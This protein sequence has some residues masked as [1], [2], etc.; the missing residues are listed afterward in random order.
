LKFYFRNIGFFFIGLSLILYLFDL[1][2]E[3]KHL[4][5][6]AGIGALIAAYF[7]KKNNFR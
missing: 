7:M 3:N 1:L 5:F 6:F 4:I 2:I